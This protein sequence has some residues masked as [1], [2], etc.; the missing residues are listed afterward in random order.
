MQ[1][2]PAVKKKIKSVSY[3]HWG[4]FFI[5]P[6]FIV[7]LIFQLY[8]IFFTFRTSLTDAMGWEKILNNNIIGFN[9]FKQ[10]F[11]SNSLVFGKFWGSLGNTMIMW[12]FNFVPQLGFALILARPMRSS[13][14]KIAEEITRRMDLSGTV[15]RTVSV[16]MNA[17]QVHQQR[18]SLLNRH[19]LAAHH[20]DKLP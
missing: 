1:A 8:P 14:R 11:D 19:F 7:F 5:A 18:L 3:S 4:Y 9:N 13:P 17:V 20:I 2:Q 12:F 16:E 6:F 10:L 15:F